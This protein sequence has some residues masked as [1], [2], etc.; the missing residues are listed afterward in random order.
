[1]TPVEFDALLDQH[2]RSERMHNYRAGL[3]AAAVINSRPRG[4]GD[5]RK[6]AMPFDF[7]N[8]APRQGLSNPHLLKA[9]SW[10]SDKAHGK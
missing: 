4:K 6:A 8:D 2:R 3:I 9:L 5:R 7:F 1:M 10:L